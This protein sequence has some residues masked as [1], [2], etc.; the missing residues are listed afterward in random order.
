MSHLKVSIQ[1]VKF[2]PIISTLAIIIS[3]VLILFGI[4]IIN[5]ISIPLATPMLMC[6][7]LYS[8]SMAFKFCK[9]HRVLIANLLL[10]ALISWINITFYRFPNLLIIR[11]V[12]LISTMS[13]LVALI[14][15]YKYGCFI[16]STK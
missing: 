12:L 9:W 16:K 1:L 4:S 5:L 13:I 3:F 15:Y 11:T 14:L 6:V 8:L 2:I 7:L 10:I